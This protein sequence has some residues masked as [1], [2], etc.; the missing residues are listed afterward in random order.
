MAALGSVRRVRYTE[1]T[2]IE[3]PGKNS[4]G[5]GTL[6]PLEDIAELVRFAFREGASDIHLTVSAPPLIRLHG[7]LVP[8][9]YAPLNQATCKKAVYSLISEELQ[10]RFEENLELDTSAQVGDTGRLR[11][12]VHR[13]RGNIEAALR[14]V[15]NQIPDFD[16]LKLPPVVKE[17]TR[18]RNGLIL[19]T[20]PTGVGKS[21]SL[22]AMVELINEERRCHI[23]KIEDPIEY[24]HT[25][26]NSIIKQRQIGED[27]HSFAQAL[28][29]SLRQDPDVI[30]LGEMR[31]LETVATAITA[32]E[33][34]HLVFATL[35]TPDAAQTIDRIIDVFPP[36][37]KEFIKVQ[38]AD[39]LQAVI[40]QQLLPRADHKGRVV[41]CEV[42]VGTSA[43]RS[44]IRVHA[45]EQVTT[46]LQT[47][48][49]H[50]MCTMDASVKALVDKKIISLNTALS[51]VRNIDDF[52][53]LMD[54]N[55]RY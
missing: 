11:I 49:S 25:N 54:K 41:A 13:Q 36:S 33:T 32:A 27:T 31:D 43:V 55:S 44:L 30:V 8:T 1:I 17:L 15:T 29:H 16:S 26:K 6:R 2:M 23:V 40:A 3:I 37:Q 34:G 10:R 46:V 35:H 14:L 18:K 39:C 45:T 38:L 19:V 50:G 5:G 22:A 12:N 21:T 9:N 28:V 20:G 7:E 48:S 52:K 53:I 24:L 47:G 51:V 4:S 42:M